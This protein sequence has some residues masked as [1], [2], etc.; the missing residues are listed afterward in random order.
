MDGWLY[1]WI[2]GYYGRRQQQQPEKAPKQQLQQQQRTRLRFVCETAMTMMTTT[3]TNEGV[4]M[5]IHLFLINAIY[6]MEN[7]ESDSKDEDDDKIYSSHTY[8]HIHIRSHLAGP[9]LS[10]VLS[11][12]PNTP[13]HTHTRS[14]IRLFDSFIHSTIHPSVQVT[15]NNTHSHSQNSQRRT[16]VPLVTENAEKCCSSFVCDDLVL[17][18][19]DSPKLALLLLLPLL[20][21]VSCVHA[22]PLKYIP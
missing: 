21:L 16:Y 7:D 19:L 15:Q 10:L 22:S 5:T 12:N 1:G 4:Y 17:D 6:Q 8:T 3:T 13:I 9:P 18:F 2:D 14:L 11:Q 20:L